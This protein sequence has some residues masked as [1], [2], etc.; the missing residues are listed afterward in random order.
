MAAHQLLHPWDF[1]GKSTG[2]GV[3]A[4]SAKLF[5]IVFILRSQCSNFKILNLREKK[6][7]S[8]PQGTGVTLTARLRCY[9]KLAWC[10]QLG[11]V[12][13]FGINYFLKYQYQTG[14]HWNHNKVTQNKTRLYTVLLKSRE[15]RVQ[16]SSQSTEHPVLGTRSD[17][18]CFTSCCFPLALVCPPYR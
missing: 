3:I 4:F 7:A 17:G 15:H 6:S 18:C 14:I 11:H 2:V 12:I 16:C 13:L 10:S 8:W 5:S 9:L 1:P